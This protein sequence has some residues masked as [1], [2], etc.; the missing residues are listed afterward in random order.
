MSRLIALAVATGLAVVAAQPTLARDNKTNSNSN[1]VNNAID[2][3]T[4]LDRAKDRNQAQSPSPNRNSN[5]VNAID[6]DK[7]AARAE[8]RHELKK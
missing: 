3:D 1:G 4:G 7:G 6:R 2:R 8:D 5:G